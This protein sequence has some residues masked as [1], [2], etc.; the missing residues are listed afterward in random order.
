MGV[1]LQEVVAH[2]DDLLAY[3]GLKDASLNGLQI[4]AGDEVKRIALAVD[5]AQVTIDAAVEHDCDLLLVHHGLFWGS[6]QPLLGALGRRVGAAF[7]GGLSIYASH[8]PLD[9]H[10]EVGNNALLA[11][12]L[13]AERERAF[14]DLGGVD[15]GTIGAFEKPLPLAELESRVAAAGCADQT[16]WR[17]G[18]DPVTNVAV[19]TGSGCSFLAE[20]VAAG[21]E[22]FITGES[23]HSAYHEASEAG[24][25]CIFAGHYATEVFGVQA[26]GRRLTAEFGV[27]TQWIEH[28]TGV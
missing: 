6:D 21:A 13:G 23:R 16:V 25:S 26:L 1:Q 18:P 9:V 8:L 15:I 22:C 17:F 20:A 10:A 3:P 2:L 4:E 12:A 27:D 24:I 19:L 11:D 5:A 14:G 7:R 28:P